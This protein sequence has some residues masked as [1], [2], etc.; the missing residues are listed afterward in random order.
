MKEVEGP[1]EGFVSSWLG[2]D[3]FRMITEAGQLF[4]E[5]GGYPLPPAG[6]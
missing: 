5:L 6:A 2:E 4:K 3:I 1:R